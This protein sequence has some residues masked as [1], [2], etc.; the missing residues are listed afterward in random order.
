MKAKSRAALACQAALEG[1]RS[2]IWRGCDLSA[3]TSRCI[4]A[5]RSQAVPLIARTVD[6]LFWS[7]D[8]GA[9]PGYGRG[10]L[11]GRST[12]GKREG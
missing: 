7:T 10:N 12:V 5:I 1:Q 3:P 9:V 11:V 6:I 2:V 8:H 4:T